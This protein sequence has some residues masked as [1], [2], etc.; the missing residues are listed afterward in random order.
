AAFLEK[1]RD[2]YRKGT[3][4][5]GQADTAG[6]ALLSLELGG[7]KPDATAEAVAEYLLLRDKDHDHWRASGNRPPS[8]VSDF[9]PTYL[10]LRALRKWGTDGQQERVAKRTEAARGWLLKAS[11]KDTEERVFRLWGLQAAGAEDT[12]LQAAA[13]EL[14]RSQRK[15]GGWGQTD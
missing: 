12:E 8:E 9:T 2:D 1:N 14:A 7:W 3:G 13:E 11:A 5:G 10:A 6:Y 15:D 4:Q